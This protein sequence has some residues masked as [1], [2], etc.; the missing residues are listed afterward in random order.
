[1]ENGRICEIDTNKS[2]FYQITEDEVLRYCWIGC[3]DLEGDID[4]LTEV[5][6]HFFS[7]L[8][9]SSP[10]TPISQVLLGF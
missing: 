1:M 8:S 2:V 3:N 7:G 9:V 5:M 6:S 4:T 10:E